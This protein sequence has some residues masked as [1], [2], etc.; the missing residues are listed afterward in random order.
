[1]ND[2]YHRPPNEIPS[3][4]QDDFTTMPYNELAVY[5]IGVLFA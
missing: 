5:M 3:A 1:M 2:I 4:T